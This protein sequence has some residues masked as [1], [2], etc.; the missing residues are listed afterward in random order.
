VSLPVVSIPV[1]ANALQAWDSA[2]LGRSRHLTL[3]IS[4]LL[5]VYPVLTKDGS[6]TPEATRK[7]I[8]LRFQVGLTPRHKPSKPH[9]QNATRSFQLVEEEKEDTPEPDPMEEDWSMDSIV[10]EPEPEQP[11]DTG[12]FERFALSTSLEA[13]LDHS[14]LNILRLR[15]RFHIGWAGGELMQSIIN[16]TQ[17]NADVVYANHKQEIK[18]ADVDERLLADN[19]ALPTDPL[20]EL[21]Q[22]ENINLPLVAF[23]YTLRRFM[24]SSASSFSQGTCDANPMP[25]PIALFPLLLRMPQQG[26][27]GL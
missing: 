6:F 23:A 24:V 19:Y 1:P 9:A 10:P 16:K 21:Q 11:E 2:L 17:I 13:L 20:V 18:K 22:R 27:P 12:L 4:G 25:A 7:G 15:I 14:F 26:R 8:S 3:L 5:D